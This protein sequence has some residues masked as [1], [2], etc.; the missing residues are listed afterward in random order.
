MPRPERSWIVVGPR[1]LIFPQD[2]L[3]ALHRPDNVLFLPRQLCYPGY[4]GQPFNPQQRKR[5]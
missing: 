5:P 3:C 4:V 1:N 2:L